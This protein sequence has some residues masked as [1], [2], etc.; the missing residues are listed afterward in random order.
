MR[1]H[2]ILLSFVGLAALG[3][4]GA[5]VLT[6]CVSIA[7]IDRPKPASFE[8][9]TVEKGAILAAIGDCTVCHTATGGEPYAGGRALATPF[10]TLYTTNITPDETTGIGGWSREAFRRAMQ[11]GVAQDGAH[12]Y[13]AL[14]YENYTHVVDGDLDAIYAFLMT[15]RPVAAKTPANDLI[16]PLG[17]RPLLA[18]WK[19]L[20]FDDERFAPDS[21]QTIEWNRGAYLVEGLGHCGGCHTPRNLAGAEESSKPLAGGI[22][23]GWTAPPLDASNPFA[24]TCTVNRLTAYLKNGVDS[25]HGIAAGPM[26][27]VIHGLSIVPE[28][29]VR[30]IAVYVAAQMNP[31]GKLAPQAAFGRDAGVSTD[32]ANDAAILY[33]KGSALFAGACAGCHDDGSPVLAEGRSS[34]SLTSDM[35]ADD[36]TNAIQAILWGIPAIAG[37]ER[38]LMPRYAEALEDEQLADLVAYLR[39]R[40]TTRSQWPDLSKTVP[41]L[42]KEASQP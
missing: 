37:R 36:P 18:G 38:P 19:L 25:A 2:T 9:A 15:R 22:A 34:L 39:V 31:G 28:A 26:G 21:S 1:L 20:F 5:Y 8:R 40:F 7:P 35:N 23:E 33:P 4:G 3:V 24:A 17:F 11:Q 12:L 27:P 29:D 30:A 16:P 42:R 41:E 10:G 13:P 6:F 32:R 14:P